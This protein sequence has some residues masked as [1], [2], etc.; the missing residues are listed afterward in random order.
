MAGAQAA[1]RE[2]SA[3][4]TTARKCTQVLGM[5]CLQLPDGFQCPGAKCCHSTLLPGDP[6]NGGVKEV[7]WS[8]KNAKLQI[9]VKRLFGLT[10]IQS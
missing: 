9:N 1:P 6:G 8:P 3:A 7:Q 2:S 10:Q 4:A 5:Q